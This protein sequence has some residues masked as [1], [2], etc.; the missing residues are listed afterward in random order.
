M[1]KLTIANEFTGLSTVVDASKPL[2]T[3]RIRD[4][5]RRLVAAECK[6]GD[7]L[8]GRGRQDNPEAYEA[9]LLRAEQVI[10]TGRDE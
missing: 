5:R 3:R 8:G 7:T 10:A 4:I 2:T 6:S 1:T 9:F